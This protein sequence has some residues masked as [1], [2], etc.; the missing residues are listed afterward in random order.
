[1]LQASDLCPGNASVR[2]RQH[3][4]NDSRAHALSRVCNSGACDQAFGPLDPRNQTGM[5][6]KLYE[7]EC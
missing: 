6:R 5:A 3:C 1:M 4:L 2:G 7:E